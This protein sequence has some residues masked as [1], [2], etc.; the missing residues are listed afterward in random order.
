MR[1]IV[2]MVAGLVVCMSGSLGAWSQGAPCVQS[3]DSRTPA[4]EQMATQDLSSGNYDAVIKQLEPLVS[5]NPQQC[6]LALLLG[7]AYLYKKDDRHAAREFRTL[8]A[9]DPTN[10]TAKL[11]LARLYGYH[12]D[13]KQSDVLYREILN[14]DA[15]DEQAS[16]GLARNLI[17][18][19][20]LPE[21]NKVVAA[22]LEAHPNSLR[23]QQYRDV[24]QRSNGRRSGED[25]TPPRPA[26]VQ[27]SLYWITDS[28]GDTVIE[29][30]SRLGFHVTKKLGA[31]VGTNVHYL[32]SVGT[33]I[34]TPDG[35]SESGGGD[36]KL[37]TSTFEGSGEL[38]FEAKRWLTLA[39][40]A[41][42]IRFGD[43]FSWALFQGIVSL[44]PSRNLYFD[45]EYL[46]LPIL[47]TRLAATFDLSAQ[48]LR[49]SIDWYPSQWRIDGNVSELKYSDGNRR[50]SQSVEILRWF[51]ERE[52]RFGAAYSGSHFTF[53]QSPLHGYFSP[54][55]YQH[56]GG[57]G[58]LQI[59]AHNGFKGEYR[60]DLGGESISGLG[61]HPVY[62]LAAHNSFQRGHLDVH[63]DY[64]RYHF[65]QSTGAFRTDVGVVGIKYH[66]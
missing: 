50:N 42:A 55:T 18:N 23:L 60:V 62:E 7:R 4:I 19:N 24:L 40:G 14:A 20:Q 10:R 48:G 49:N 16:V 22:G 41:G 6:G 11:E 38:D 45:S 27:T 29:S 21:A 32:S 15:S 66:F 13:Y 9:A 63:A 35:N 33:V 37:S 43:G 12:S 39:A 17:T 36:T 28:A 64:T 2:G 31:H 30:I 3:L 1:C 26:D 51:G 47:P 8:L 53:S 5:A 61:F 52:V 34:Q 57:A 56:H 25:H 44:H 58:L 65:T 54:D 46:R 59:R